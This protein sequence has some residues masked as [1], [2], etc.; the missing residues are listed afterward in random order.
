MA[1]PPANEVDLWGFVWK[2]GL[3]YYW[4][5]YHIWVETIIH[6]SI[7]SVLSSMSLPRLIAVCC[8][9]SPAL[10]FFLLLGNLHVTSIHKF[11]FK[12]TYLK[13]LFQLFFNPVSNMGEFDLTFTKLWS[14]R[15]KQHGTPPETIPNNVSNL[16][17]TQTENYYTPW[18]DKV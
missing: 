9:T 3:D 12:N 6:T 15:D 17:L 2:A 18:T 14:C 8:R 1:V 7:R 10:L 5:S 16:N 11:P 13:L 4:L